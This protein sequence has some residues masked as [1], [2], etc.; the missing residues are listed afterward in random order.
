VFGVAAIGNV[1]HDEELNLHGLAVPQDGQHLHGQH[2]LVR[3][4]LLRVVPADVDDVAAAV[5]RGKP[6]RGG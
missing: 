3:R 4:Q 2:L 5:Q 1:R 6:G